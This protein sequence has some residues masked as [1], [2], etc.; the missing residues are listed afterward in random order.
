VIF[1]HTRIVDQKYIN[2]TI[3]RYEL[4]CPDGGKHA[5][6]SIRLLYFYP[7]MFLYNIWV[8]LNTDS[9]VRII[10]DSLRI[11][12]NLILIKANPY[13]TNTVRSN[14]CH[15]GDFCFA[16]SEVDFLLKNV[17]ILYGTF[18][19]NYNT[20]LLIRSILSKSESSETILC[21]LFDKALA[22]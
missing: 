16:V 12:I 5:R 20:T 3:P 8:I 17:E 14:S 10:A 9:G 2:M 6:Q 22:T 13:A 19:N 11:F 1:Y 21:I 15:E 18:N 7:G 4:T